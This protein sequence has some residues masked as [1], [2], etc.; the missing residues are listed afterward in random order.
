MTPRVER[1]PLFARWRTR[2]PASPEGIRFLIVG[3]LAYLVSQ[4]CLLLLYDLLPLLPAKGSPI[5]L[6]FL[7]HPD[8][9]LL[10]AS[11]AAVEAAV[12][13]KFWAHE[14]W[15][16][17]DR[18]VEGRIAYRFLA[19]NA[20]CLVSSVISIATVNVVTLAFAVSPY[21]SNTLGA[22]GSVLVNWA[23]SAYVIWRHAPAGGAP[24][25]HRSA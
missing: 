22:L 1:I 6:P 24:G 7:T 12:I 15:T 17:R 14:R 3:A 23:L 19:F 10:V 16:F 4:L 8:G 11:I 9:R 13:F 25:E 2:L 20:S 18:R 21:V 5:T